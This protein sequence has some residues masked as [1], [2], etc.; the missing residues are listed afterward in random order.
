MPAASY[1]ALERLLHHLALGS[2]AVAEFSF[3][4]DRQFLP[5]AL[6]DGEDAASDG[7]HVFVCGLAR[8]GTTIVMRRLH[9]TGLFRSLTYRDMPFV[10]APNLWRRLSR[11]APRDIAAAERA[12]GDR[13]TVDADSPEALDEVFWRVF[14]GSDYIAPDHLHPHHVE[15]PVLARFRRYVAAILA[16][17]RDGDSPRRY[18]SK[19]NNAILR[20]DA[21]QRAF[22]RAAIVIPFRDPLQHAQSL[23]AQHR[24]FS[25]LQ[26]EDKFARAYMGWLAHH[27]FGLDHRPFRFAASLAD[28]GEADTARLDYWLDLW[29][30]TYAWLLRTRPANAFFVGYETLCADPL[31]WD[32]ILAR[33]DIAPGHPSGEPFAPAAPRPVAEADPARAARAR[34]LYRELA[35]ASRIVLDAPA[36]AAG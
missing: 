31:A 29:L 8:A 9:A 10:L 27:E 11:L 28:A 20:L 23:R 35:A 6:A 15:E 16:S 17:R 32:R 30:D 34:D 5:P 4:L 25:R 22:P 26:A 18:L 2:R 3:D 33:L 12:H 21:L 1:S 19:N 24:R 13:L 36:R 7:R 14:A